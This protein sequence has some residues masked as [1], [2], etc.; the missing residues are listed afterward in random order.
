MVR[1][2]G[3]EL[4]GEEGGTAGL[5]NPEGV[6]TLRGDYGSR[7]TPSRFEQAG[8][9]N[10]TLSD[11]PCSGAQQDG[12]RVG[13]RPK[14]AEAAEAMQG[15]WDDV[16]TDSLKEPHALQSKMQIGRGPSKRNETLA[17]YS[18]LS[19]DLNRLKGYG[20]AVVPACAEW[21]GKRLMAAAPKA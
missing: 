4:G 20:N 18:H 3:R 1:L 11:V 14:R 6:R 16:S 8:G 17:S 7:A 10:S 19:R 12:S 13:R 9:N 2:D 15:M 21:I 5:P